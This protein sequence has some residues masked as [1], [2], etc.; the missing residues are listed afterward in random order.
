[1]KWQAI[2]SPTISLLKDDHLF[3]LHDKYKWNDSLLFHP[4][5]LFSYMTTTSSISMISINE[6]PGYHF[7]ISLLIHDH[8]FHLHDKYKLQDFTIKYKRYPIITAII[9]FF[10]HDHLFHLHDKYKW[11]GSRSF[12]PSYLFSNITTSSI[13]MD[14]YRCPWWGHIF[15]WLC[16]FHK[17]KNNF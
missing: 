6:M 16:F 11:N 1:M 5:Y 2:I 7:T 4:P 13:S 17:N 8:L 9:H 15:I 14:R 3:L 10:K 12:Q